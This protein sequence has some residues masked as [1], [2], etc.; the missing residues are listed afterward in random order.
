MLQ[1]TDT[2]RSLE[3][4]VNIFLNIINKHAPL[5][6]KRVKRKNQPKWF[7]S[8]ISHAIKMR[9]ASKLKEPDI[10]R[11]WRNKVVNLIL[12]QRYYR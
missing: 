5:K 8:D 6:E 1:E 9:D 3:N 4:W 10:Y 7:N 12:F 11:F 2:N